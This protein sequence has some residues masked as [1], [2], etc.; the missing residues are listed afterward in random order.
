MTS[1]NN[2]V[3]LLIT[4]SPIGGR[5]AALSYPCHRTGSIIQQFFYVPCPSCSRLSTA[6]LFSYCINFTAS[7]K[8]CTYHQNSMLSK[9]LL[10]NL[11]HPVLITVVANIEL[12]P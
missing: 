3:D 8:V 11:L 7:S 4:E 2:Y 5:G 10:D 12:G 1:E 9:Y 6:T